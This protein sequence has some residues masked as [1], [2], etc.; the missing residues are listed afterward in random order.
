MDER[1]AAA[2]LV[3]QLRRSSRVDPFGPAGLGADRDAH[4]AQWDAELARILRRD[5]AEHW[6]RAAAS[7][8]ALGRPHDAGYCRWRAAQCAI[9]DDRG[10]VA[11]R[12]LKKAASDAREHV[13]LSQAIA[14]TAAGGR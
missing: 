6:N 3:D 1:E 7:F 14:E 13:P 9:R 2:R 4:A 10:T 12:L 5:D 8:D 11:A